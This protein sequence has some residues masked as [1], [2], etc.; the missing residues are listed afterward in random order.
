[1]GENDFKK[2]F[3]ETLSTESIIEKAS[4]GIQFVL[5]FPKGGEGSEVQSVLFDKD[6]WTTATAQAWLKSHDFSGTE[7]DEKENTLRFRQKDPGKYTRFATITPGTKKQRD[8]MDSIQDD[9]TKKMDGNDTYEGGNGGNV[10]SLE[11]PHKPLKPGQKTPAT[12]KSIIDLSEVEEFKKTGGAPFQF[13]IE[14][15]SMSESGEMQT[16]IVRKIDGT[17]L[18]K[19]QLPEH[20]YVEGLATTTNVDHD[21]ERMS[22][23]A[24]QAM[25][26][27]INKNGVP[28]ISEHSKEWDG[29]LGKVFEA[30]VDDRNQLHIKAELDKD[31]SKSVDLYNA[32][33]KGAQL[34]LSIAGIV[35][36]AGLEMVEGVGK[37][38]KT[39][40]D[41]LLKEVSVTGRPSN[42]DTWLVAKGIAKSRESGLYDKYLNTDSYQEYL[43]SNPRLD[44]Q[45]SIA[46]SVQDDVLNKN[47]LNMDVIKKEET[48]AD[49][50][51]AE[52]KTEEVKEEVK[53]EDTKAEEVKVEEVKTEEVKAPE[54]ETEKA[55]V[56]KDTVDADIEK[57]VSEQ[58]AKAKAET[59]SSAVDEVVK[60]RI[61]AIAAKA[62]AIAMKHLDNAFKAMGGDESETTSDTEDTETK[63]APAKKTKKAIADSSTSED[64]STE[65]EM[66]SDT[67]SSETETKPAAKKTQ[68]AKPA[69][70]TEDTDTT[71][72][73]DDE[74]ETTSKSFVQAIVSGVTANLEKKQ[75]RVI[76]NL[77]E[78]VEKMMQVPNARKG[79]AIAMEKKFVG[80]AI[81]EQVEEGK[82]EKSEGV[83]KTESFQDYFKTNFSSEKK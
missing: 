2:F 23:E 81:E 10:D 24:I 19:Q 60:S 54:A 22:P 26:A 53:V 69:P 3:K 78:A 48:S 71:E 75:M 59:I 41:V 18:R 6:N 36:K 65:K 49:V 34:G 25:E 43:K 73:E 83:K 38:C 16:V 4:K 67:D 30:R 55:E 58:V 72:T 39:F 12:K 52:E 11:Q 8:F 51:P 33:K 29:V 28:L 35:K 13:F 76:G 82:V 17:V 68:K 37:K 44:W 57:S 1:M 27:E 50:K 7:V 61:G 66:D 20:L 21:Q 9:K 14:K 70:K 15:A 32:L 64:T 74:S 62:K 77:Q 42:F 31:M 80:N 40:Y 63:P 79:I 46:K 47:I 5:G 45:Y 56:E